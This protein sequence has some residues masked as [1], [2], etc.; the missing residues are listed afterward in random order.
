MRHVRNNSTL[1][2]RSMPTV[3]PL[4]HNAIWAPRVAANIWAAGRWVAEADQW[5]ALRAAAECPTVAE[6]CLTVV[7]ALW[8][9]VS[10]MAVEAL[11]VVVAVIL[12]AII[13]KETE[14]PFRA[15]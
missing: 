13:H 12:A 1:V 10:P 4:N 2:N 6:E 7:V 5:A 9:V 3:C 14:K 15:I 11:R 8:E